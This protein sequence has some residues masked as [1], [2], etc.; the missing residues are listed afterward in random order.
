M[1]H[2]FFRYIL[3]GL[4]V[5]IAVPMAVY[6]GP[7]IRSGESVSIESDKVVEG[8]LYAVGGSVTL[9]GE[10]RGDAYIA[11]GN[12]TVN[13]PIDA[14][15]VIAGGSVNIHSS[16]ADDVRIVGGSVTL[17]GSVEGDVLVTGGSL[18]ILS[19]AEIKGDLIF[20]AGDIDVEGSVAGSLY[21]IV[22]SLRIDASIGG[23]IDISAGTGLTLGDRAEVLGDITYRARTDLVRAPNAVVVG[24]TQK[25][26]IADTTTPIEFYVIPL[27]T[28]LFAALTVFL[29]LRKR[30]DVFV[31]DTE[32]NYGTQGLIGLAVFLGIPF[33]GVILTLSVL[34]LLV[35]IAVLAV[36]V[37][38][39]CA[40]WVA[41]G[42]VL[43]TIAIR[44][45][46]KNTKVTLI[47]VIVGVLVLE[48]VTFIPY[49]GPL[50][51]LAAFL[52]VLGGIA[53]RLYKA[54]S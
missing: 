49:I 30:L 21:G 38:L 14:D 31:I 25:E 12:V 37:A 35:G 6:A 50:L 4:L 23:N 17:A 8:D 54:I 36:Y 41:T 11:G 52:T 34:G 15:L 47:S 39:L 20:A 44:F 40:A 22:D 26:T 24:T 7:V 2:N 18:H 46:Q 45:V 42:I 27:L 33:V 3:F 16:V 5:A 19:T 10:V 43:G 28:L 48:A 29:L 13:A 51:A 32:Q 1:K 9:S 53:R